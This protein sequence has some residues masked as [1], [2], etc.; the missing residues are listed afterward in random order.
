M[1]Q[2]EAEA[3]T[4]AMAESKR[5]HGKADRAQSLEGSRLKSRCEQV[6]RQRGYPEQSGQARAER[7]S[8]GA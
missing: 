7:K 3:V 5:K 1:R 4:L 8:R 6:W 2:D